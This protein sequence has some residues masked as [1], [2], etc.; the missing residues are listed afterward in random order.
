[1]AAGETPDKP[2]GLIAR[3]AGIGAICAMLLFGLLLALDWTPRNASELVFSV[4]ALVFSVGLIGWSTVL[5]AGEAMEGFSSE[6]G[7]SEG[8]TVRSG[9]QAMALLV[10][11]GGGGM[12]GAAL[13]GSPFGV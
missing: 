7:L 4:A 12:V 11:G 1:M 6:L 13:A 2:W 3:A 9:R 5:M 10:A 8:W